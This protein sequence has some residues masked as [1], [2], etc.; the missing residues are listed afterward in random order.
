M[1]VVTVTI[2]SEGQ[3][4]DP[5]YALLSLELVKEVNRIPYAQ[6]TLEDGDA[7]ERK[8]L[9]SD[10]SFF[11]PGK[12]IEI[13]LRYEGDPKSE[14][15]VFKGLVVRHGLEANEHASVLKVELK[16]EAVKLSHVRRSA[17]YA[18][19]AD[20][21]IM[22]TLISDNG[23]SAGKIS[24]T[25]AEHEQLVQYSCTDWDFLLSRA[26]VNGLVVV[27][28]D[29]KISAVK[30][31]ISGSA[32]HE[33]EYGMAEIYNF[34]I[35]ADIEQQFGTVQSIG[36]DVKNQQATSPSKA[37]SVKLE[38]G[39]LDGANLAN[40]V[41]ADT[42]TLNSSVSLEPEE[43]QAWSD[44]TLL[45]SRL[46]MIR[47]RISVAGIGDIKPLDIIEIKG[48]GKRFNGKTL[49]TGI[50]HEVTING[51]QTDVQFGLSPEAF[52]LHPN[53]NDMPA[54]GLLPPVNGLQIGIVDEFEEDS[55]KELR[56]RVTLPGLTD[57]EET[58]WARLATPDAGNE[59][60]YFFYPEPGDEV[61]VGFF[62]DDP[63]QA[64]ILGAMFGSKNVL[65]KGLSDPTADNIEKAIVTRQGTIIGF[66][67]ND[68]AS[69]FIRTPAENEFVLD[70]DAE[71]ISL[72][73]QHGNSITMS[74]DGIEIKSA[75]DVIIDASGDVQIKGT[76][77][78]V[79]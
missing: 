24:T 2:Q 30:P 53:I 13:K 17:V 23:L 29:G 51:W 18:K 38:Q 33:F 36:W 16:D 4:L 27:V 57:V 69:V 68:K 42:V 6:L 26:D 25:D 63:R 5:K 48:M 62:N 58:I 22:K 45:R 66:L 43:L 67:D 7:G 21:K 61:V 55:E 46:S 8:F 19:Q 71:T 50:R 54:G 74:K 70:D 64:V 15:T 12:T 41:G 76:N 3:A 39:N 14:K 77:V 31:E 40:V 20:S 37:K 10:E 11:E 75:K 59:R 28:D 65:P 52:A 34:E 44:A 73:D 1:S 32:D 78:D 60:G 79:K 47:G 49:V 35:E 9:L 56:V 72:S